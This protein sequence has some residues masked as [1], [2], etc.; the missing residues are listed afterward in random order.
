MDNQNILI[1]NNKAYSNNNNILFDIIN[2]LNN[3]VENINNNIQSDI[4][5]NQIKNIII[6]MNNVINDNKKNIDLII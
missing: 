6:I 5:I 4:I 1:L 3:I 2:K